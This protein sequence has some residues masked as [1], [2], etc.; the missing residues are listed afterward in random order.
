MKEN[1]VHNGEFVITI[2]IVSRMADK[3]AN[4]ISLFFGKGY[5]KSSIKVD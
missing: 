4:V 2:L 5:I 3:D 1:F